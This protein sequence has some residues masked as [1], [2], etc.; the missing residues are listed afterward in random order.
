MPQIAFSITDEEATAVLTITGQNAQT[1]LERQA[2][3]HLAD[4]RQKHHARQLDAS[5][6][7]GALATLPLPEGALESLAALRA[8]AMAK[9]EAEVEAAT[10]ALAVV[11]AKREIAAR[12]RLLERRD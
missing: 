8:L 4:A 12:A 5:G 6:L 3:V 10:G 2:R 11:S 7:P 9:D 1:W